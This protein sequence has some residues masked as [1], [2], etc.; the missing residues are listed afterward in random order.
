MSSRSDDVRVSAI[1]AFLGAGMDPKPSTATMVALMAEARR[2]AATIADQ[3]DELS[4]WLASQLTR[5][6]VAENAAVVIAVEYLPRPCV[7]QIALAYIQR[8][9]DRDTALIA[10]R[11]ALA[12]D[13]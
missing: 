5:S 1:V 12:N 8:H 9:P 7:D 11:D 3:P 2:I 4:T 6:G 10:L 13:P